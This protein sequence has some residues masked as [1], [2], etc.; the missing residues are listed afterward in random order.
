[1][2]PH[3]Y[4]LLAVLAAPDTAGL[5]SVRQSRQWHDLG[6]GLSRQPA[7][8]VAGAG[9]ARGLRPGLHRGATGGCLARARL[10]PRSLARL[11]AAAPDSRLPVLLFA[12]G[13]DGESRAGVRAPPRGHAALAV[14]AVC[15][16]CGA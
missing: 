12:V 6:G 9:G 3:L 7:G 15:C 4:E 2:R 8:V 1:C 13:D 14:M 10:P 5:V 11:G 16:G